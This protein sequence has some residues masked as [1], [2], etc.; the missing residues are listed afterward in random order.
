MNE[1][2]KGYYLNKTGD[3]VPFGKYHQLHV[4]NVRD[5]VLNDS[6]LKLPIPRAIGSETELTILQDYKGRANTIGSYY[7]LLYYPAHSACFAYRPTVRTDLNTR[8]VEH[9]WWLPSYGEL[10]RIAYYYGQYLSETTNT[11][12]NKLN[13]FRGAISSSIMDVFANNSAYVTTAEYRD[14]YYNN[15][16]QIIISTGSCRNH[17]KANGAKVRAVTSF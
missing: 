4:I 3:R 15:F 14:S 11:E 10:V 2:L 6:N 12:E 16:Y 17:A 1:N 8:F 7:N 5:L 9:N 13:I